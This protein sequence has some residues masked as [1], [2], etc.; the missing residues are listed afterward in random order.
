VRARW[1]HADL[2]NIEG[3]DRLQI[4]IP[5]KISRNAYVSWIPLPIDIR[6]NHAV[7]HTVPRLNS[8]VHLHC[9]I[10]ASCNNFFKGLKVI[11]YTTRS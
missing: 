4:L 1:P 6:T 11:Y 9:S 3:A 2:E 7:G 10:V 8:L 5:S